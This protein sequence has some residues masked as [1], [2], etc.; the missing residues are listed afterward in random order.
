MGE[1]R[2]STYIQA[3]FE[4]ISEG[5][6]SVEG[7]TVSYIGE[8]VDNAA[9]DKLLQLM[10]SGASD[11]RPWLR[12]IDKLMA[13][14]SYSSREQLYNFLTHKHMP[15]TKDGNVIGYKGVN[16]DYTDI[17]SGQFDN[18]IGNEHSMPRARVDDNAGHGCSAGFHI[19][20][21][22][23][24]DSW[25][26]NGRLMVVEFS[27]TDAVSVPNDSNWQKLRVCRYKVVG[28]SFTRKPV[29]EGLYGDD[30]YDDSDRDEKLISYLTKRWA[31]SKSPKLSKL[32]R[33]FPGLTHEELQLAINNS[34][35]TASAEWDADASDYRVVLQ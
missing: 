30:A 8:P 16:E 21:H 29:S 3:H 1:H 4:R 22:D 15:I 18:S 10:R 12:F 2:R 9:S 5:N 27:P 28:E 23:Y 35:Y 13:N 14:P 19:G 25:G 26:S 34:P 33:K 31:K 7:N 6:V 17:Y 11:I 24:A 20:S 32:Y